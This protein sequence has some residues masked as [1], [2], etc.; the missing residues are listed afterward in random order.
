MKNIERL[1]LGGGTMA[2]IK[3]A[4]KRVQTNEKKRLE[5]QSVK[6]E[7]RSYIKQVESLI[8]ANDA[9]N[10]KAAYVKAA[11]KID[12]SVQRGIIHK[13]SGNR[14][15]SRLAKKLKSLSV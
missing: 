7:M 14:Q 2:N 6:S 12:K 5:N 15:K 3:S 1:Y 9:E 10:A 4:I 13:N 8:E 11:R